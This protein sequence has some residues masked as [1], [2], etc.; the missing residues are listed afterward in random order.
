MN[1]RAVLAS[2]LGFLIGVSLGALG[3]GGSIL[4]VPVLVFVAGQQPSHATSTSLVVV[5]LASLIGAYGH[6]RSGRVRVVPGVVFGLVGIAGS[7]V[8]SALNRRLD[9]D[10]LLLAFSFLIVIAAWRILVGCPSCTRSGEAA[11]VAVDQ[12]EPAQGPLLTR[13]RTWAP[14]RIA[15][16]AA[17]GT[18]VGFLTGLFGVGGGFVIVPALALVLEFPMGA[19][20]GTSLL[21]IAINTAVALA[22]RAGTGTI[23]WG[24]TLL[25]SAAAIAGVGAGKRLADRLEPQSTQRAFAALLV[26]LA[27][28]TG[29]RSALAIF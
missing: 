11:A 29:A 16:V 12:H 9:G 4:A 13:T 15:K 7:L 22:A 20:V 26:A 2:P 21:V 19:A 5:G 28:Y 25:F 14:G 17:A 27:I 24:I 6:W 18:V 3:G 8:G 23:D 1:L 10:V